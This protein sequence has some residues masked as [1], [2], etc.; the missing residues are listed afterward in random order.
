M[1]RNRT[2]RRYHGREAES[3]YKACSIPR[4]HQQGIAQNE[5]A[6]AAVYCRHITRWLS[7]SSFTTE[8][9]SFAE[10]RTEPVFAKK[11]SV[12]PHQCAVSGSGS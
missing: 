8:N 9:S 12:L 5:S 3:R 6:A 4:F 2:G 10:S 1:T 7:V 11:N